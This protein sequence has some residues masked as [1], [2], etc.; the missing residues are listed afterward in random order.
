VS[1]RTNRW[2][3]LGFDTWML[4]VESSAVIARRTLN[5]AFAG[6]WGADEANLMVAEKLDAAIAWQK[7]A[8][9]GGLGLNPAAAASRTVSHY[10]RRVRANNRRLAKA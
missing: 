2:L 9:T 7:L 6:P 5:A 3:S 10:R 8:M 4:G 1:R